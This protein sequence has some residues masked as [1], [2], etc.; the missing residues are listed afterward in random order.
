MLAFHATT[1][2]FDGSKLPRTAKVTRGANKIKRV[3][4]SIMLTNLRRDVELG[5]VNPITE[6]Q[7]LYLDRKA[8]DGIASATA[9]LFAHYAQERQR[10]VTTE[11]PASFW[12]GPHELRAMVQYMREP[13]IVLG[14][15]QHGDAHVQK[16]MYKDYRIPDGSVH[17]SGYVEALPDMVARDYLCECWELYTIPA[18]L[19]LR[20]NEMR[21]NGVQHGE[22]LTMWNV[23]GNSDYADT[24]DASFG[25]IAGVQQRNADRGELL[26]DGEVL[27]R[28]GHVNAAIIRDCPT[29][30]YWGAADDRRGGVGIL[31]NPYGAF[32]N[33]QPLWSN[34]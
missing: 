32:A 17:E 31:I 9:S 19:V 30:S 22:L 5:L 12:A 21:F 1:S 15:N 20:R 28:P 26:Q 13:L 27:A 25:W 6:L 11:V 14:V 24:L 34:N 23:E 33:A 2:S 16:Y 18:M 8:G 10:S 29:L 7:R 3:I 4:Y